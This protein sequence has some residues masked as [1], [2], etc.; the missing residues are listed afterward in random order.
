V[1]T[2]AEGA[3]PVC[4]DS[5]LSLV[6]R[7][8]TVGTKQLGI[9]AS[10]IVGLALVSKACSVAPVGFGASDCG[11]TRETQYVPTSTWA[12][13]ERD[14]QTVSVRRVPWKTLTLEVSNSDGGG[15]I[16]RVDPH[17]SID[18][19][20]EIATR[21]RSDRVWNHWTQQFEQVHGQVQVMLK[22]SNCWTYVSGPNDVF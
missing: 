17:G 19:G 11:G 16:R 15:A 10:C 20:L 3:A 14:G 4:D 7:R 12:T 9:V 2:V 5:V 13:F 21:L 22:V 18:D 8:S 1:L 6:D